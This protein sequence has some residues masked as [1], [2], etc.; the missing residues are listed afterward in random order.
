MKKFSLNISAL[1]KSIQR[2]LVRFPFVMVMALG[3]FGVGIQLIHV[4]DSLN[5]DLINLLMTL[6]LGFCAYISSTLISE[7]KGWKRSKQLVMELVLL[8]ALVAYFFLLPDTQTDTFWFE[9][10]FR[11]SLWL[12]GCLFL[13]CAAPFLGRKTDVLKTW[14]FNRQIFLSFVRTVFYGICLFVGLVIAFG[15]TEELLFSLPEEIYPDTWLSIVTILGSLFFLDGIPPKAHDLTVPKEY[16]KEAKIFSQF[17]LL[18]LVTIYFAILYLYSF[19][20]L[21]TWEWPEGIISWMII[22]FSFLGVLTYFFL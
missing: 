15:T 2:V 4:D 8:V 5:S 22:L 11:H 9:P 13:I 18:P 12:V 7:Q 17:I 20:I 3:C 16:P 19:K 10:S 21:S 6:T 1:K 14:E